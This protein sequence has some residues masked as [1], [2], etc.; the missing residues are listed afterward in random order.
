MPNFRRFSLAERNGLVDYVRYLAIRGEVELRLVFDF[1][2]EGEL[3][4]DAASKEFL[5]VW[6]KW[7]AALQKL[8]VYDGDVPPPTKDRIARGDSLF[9]DA[10]KGN[11]SSCHGD[12]GAGDGPAS[13]KMGVDGKPVPAYLDAWGHPILPRDLR[14]GLL[15]GGSRPIDV[16]RRI[17]SGINGGPMP[18]LGQTKDAQGRPLL[19]AADL[20]C[21]VHYVR[22]LSERPERPERPEAR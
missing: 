15:R 4:P 10:T 14:Q 21:L 16:Y 19:D 17:Y 7:R 20:W 18:A 12:R 8:V 9:H 5:D 2:E 13:L 3:A 22:S 6:E 11:C 1:K